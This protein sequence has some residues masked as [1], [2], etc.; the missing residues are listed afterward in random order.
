MNAKQDFGSKL[1][2]FVF[3]FLTFLKVSP[4]C[5]RAEKPENEG[6]SSQIH[7][8]DPLRP[9][10]ADENFELWIIQIISVVQS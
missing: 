8:R 4:D 3:C 5:R 1:G 9:G 7:Y 2:N 6:F 10:R